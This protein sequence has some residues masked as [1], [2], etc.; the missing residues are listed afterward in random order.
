MQKVIIQI[1]IYGQFQIELKR[2]FCPISE[3]T[4]CQTNF[5]NLVAAGLRFDVEVYHAL[6]QKKSLL[7]QYTFGFKMCAARLNVLAIDSSSED[8]YKLDCLL[9]KSNTNLKFCLEFPLV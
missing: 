8:I 4:H 7:Y 9:M 1:S 6:I 2:L 3:Q 5:V